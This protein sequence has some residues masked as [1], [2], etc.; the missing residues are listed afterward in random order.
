MRKKK[1]KL[2]RNIFLLALGIAIIPIILLVSSSFLNPSTQALTNYCYN[3]KCVPEIVFSQLPEKPKYFTDVS[4]NMIS[5]VLTQGIV[6]ENFSNYFVPGTNIPDE[7]YYLRPEFYERGDWWKRCIPKYVSLED[8]VLY[9]KEI[10][11]DYRG[12]MGHAI[13]PGGLQILNKKPGDEFYVTLYVFSNCDVYKWQGVHLETVFPSKTTLIQKLS[14]KSLEQDPE[15]AKQ[16]FNVKIKPDNLL[17]GPTFPMFWNK[18]KENRWAH[19]VRLHV[20]ISE[21]AEPG[22]YIISLKTTKPP[23]SQINTWR[24]NYKIYRYNIVFPGF[25]QGDYPF[26][27]ILEVV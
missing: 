22:I 25:I 24:N 15:K 4:V 7:K 5:E 12:I 27:M 3:N 9:G 20:K 13:Y 8:N 26:E 16:Y 19:Q 21:N 1:F 10:S 18:N 23:D 11:F 6:Y 14:G 2:N 17:L